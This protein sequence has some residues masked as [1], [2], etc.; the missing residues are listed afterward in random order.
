MANVKIIIIIRMLGSFQPPSSSTH[1]SKAVMWNKG[2][3][4]ATELPVSS[5]MPMIYRRKFSYKPSAILEAANLFNETH[6][7]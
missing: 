7:G 6:R 4:N 2:A 3:A 1:V 5:N